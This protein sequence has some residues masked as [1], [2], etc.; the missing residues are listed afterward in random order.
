MYNKK[1]NK[2]GLILGTSKFTCH[3]LSKQ[4]SKTQKEN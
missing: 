3:K 2:L 4:E 1:M